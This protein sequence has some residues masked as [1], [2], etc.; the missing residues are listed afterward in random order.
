MRTVRAPTHL[1]G[2]WLECGGEWRTYGPTHQT[3]SILSVF[4][5][6]ISLLFFFFF[7]SKVIV[8]YQALYKLMSL[9]FSRNCLG[10]LWFMVFPGSD[11]EVDWFY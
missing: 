8:L 5:S 9:L 4:L 7:T 2:A 11:Y 3:H 1:H 10:T 6:H